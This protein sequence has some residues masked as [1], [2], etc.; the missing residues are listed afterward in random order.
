LD[1]V[2]SRQCELAQ[3]STSIILKTLRQH[4]VMLPCV[5]VMLPCV[6]VMLLCVMVMLPCVMPDP[7][8]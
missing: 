4:Q 6:M 7:P 2:V 1:H 8:A 3:T 5:M